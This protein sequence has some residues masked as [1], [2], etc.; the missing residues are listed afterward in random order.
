[1]LFNS[2]EFLIFFPV[3]VVLYFACPYRYRWMLLL[4]ASYTFYAALKLEYVFLLIA[5]TM[6]SYITAILV[7]KSGNQVQRTA[8]L[9]I[10][11]CSNLGILFAFKYFNFINDSFRTVFNQFNLVYNVPMFQMLLP[12]GISFYIFQ[13]LGYLIDVYQ[14]R[15][16]PE[17]HLGRFALF[18]AFFP[19]LLAGPIGRATN[20]LPQFYKKNDFDEARVSSGL[21]LMLWG[22]F[23]KVVIADRLALYVN[24]VYDNPSEWT[25]WPILLA[26]LFFAFQIYCDFSGYSDI[27]IGAARVMGFNLMENF[28]RPYLARSPAEFWRCWHISLS[29]WFRDYLYIPLGG[30]RVSV[31]RW[32]LN[33]LI[34]FLV[35]GL[36][37]GAAWTFVLWGGLHGLYMVGDVAT[38]GL[39]GKLTHRLGL[40][41][42]PTISEILGWTV[43][44]SLV[45]LAWIFFRANSVADAFL[46]LHNLT[47][48][49]NF[50]DFNAPWASA[51]SNPAQE[52]ALSLGL[53]LLLMVVNWV[54][55]QQRQVTIFW[56]Q[57]LWFRWVAYLSLALAIMNL[58]LTDN[59]PFIYFQ[60]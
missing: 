51:V 53:V 50:T 18:A 29:T 54:Q 46:L 58:G 47:P 35:S 5:S 52:M 57:P 42:R 21:R 26:T 30:S 59:A 24:V 14:G 16:Q 4:I 9:V 20:M 10:G 60:F 13:T 15:L 6:I 49:T 39:R 37:H 55:E 32:Y 8:L 12:I 41:R 25:G 44:F 23:K 31:M 48:L 34:V 2:I 43:T 1:M 28:R 36:W 56:Q 19:Q 33:L 38:Q 45:C 3:V 22:M 27:A 7:V 17:R 11:L 40:A